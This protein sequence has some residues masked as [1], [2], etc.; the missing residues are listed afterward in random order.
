MGKFLWVSDNDLTLGEKQRIHNKNVDQ[1][2][3]NLLEE[4]DLTF[5]ISTGKPIEY[6]FQTYLFQLIS[7]IKVQEKF[8]LLKKIGLTGSNGALTWLGFDDNNKPLKVIKFDLEDQEIKKAIKEVNLL[9]RHLLNTFGKLIKE[10]INAEVDK[11]RIVGSV[12]NV[13]KD[14]ATMQ[15]RY[16]GKKEIGIV[17]NCSE[18]GLSKTPKAEEFYNEAIKFIEENNLNL[19]KLFKHINTLDIVP[20][21]NGKSLDKSYPIKKIKNELGEV[22]VIASGD[23]SNDLDLFKIADQTIA[24]LNS[25]PEIILNANHISGDLEKGFPFTAL[26][27]VKKVKEICQDNKY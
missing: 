24:P 11:E 12:V 9:T 5:I 1:E 4:N 14:C 7:M 17:R 23:H 27:I 3:I 16:L 21:F 18:F 20:K 6:A 13:E 10:Q 25:H 19:I 2:I 15:M 8:H 22:T 26:E